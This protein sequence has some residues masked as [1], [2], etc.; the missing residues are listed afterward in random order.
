MLCE[1]C[2]IREATVVVREIINGEKTEHHYC[3][4]CA[5]KLEF[6]SLFD[7]D[8]PLGGILS[9]LLGLGDSSGG[10][11]GDPAENLA[12]PTC[13]TTYGDFIRDGRFGCSDCYETFG[14]LIRDKIKRVQGSDAHVGKHPKNIGGLYR[15]AREKITQDSLNEAIAEAEKKEKEFREG[16][17]PAPEQIRLLREKQQQAVEKEDYEEAAKIRDQIRALKVKENG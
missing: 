1:Q 4:Q 6:G 13:G 12:C 3:A 16:T 8:S 9:G 11:S 10:D 17:L 2:H 14:P 15:E 5:S 7:S